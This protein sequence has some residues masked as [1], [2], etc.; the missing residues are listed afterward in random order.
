MLGKW[1]HR[2]Q[3]LETAKRTRE[4]EQREAFRKRKRLNVGVYFFPSACFSVSFF[5]LS[6]FRFIDIFFAW[7]RFLSILTD[8]PPTADPAL[9]QTKCD[10]SSL[11]IECG[12]RVAWSVDGAV[13][14]L[15]I[16]F[17]H[18]QTGLTHRRH[19][20]LQQEQN[21]FLVIPFQVVKSTKHD[22]HTI[23]H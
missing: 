21:Q 14:S 13:P 12:A 3:L 2:K 22:N 20:P 4:N 10:F 5:S 9:W 11:A 16:L 17:R 8:D 7:W 19:Q 15:D 18:H 6:L 1:S 23:I